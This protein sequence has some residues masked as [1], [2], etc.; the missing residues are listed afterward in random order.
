MLQQSSLQNSACISKHHQTC[1]SLIEREHASH[2]I[3]VTEFYS[4]M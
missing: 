4:E 3:V 2:H 1:K